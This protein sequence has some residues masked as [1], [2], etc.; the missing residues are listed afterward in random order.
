MGGDK[1]PSASAPGVGEQDPP[2]K[3]DAMNVDDSAEV[4]V[5]LLRYFAFPLSLNPQPSTM[6]L[7]ILDGGKAVLSSARGKPELSRASRSGIP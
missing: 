5:S 4:E 2:C 6:H 1:K 3:S 7:Y